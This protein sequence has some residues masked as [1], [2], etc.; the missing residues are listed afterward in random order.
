MNL[1]V[2][3][4]W[5]G[6][7]CPDKSIRGN[8]QVERTDG[9][10]LITAT[11]PKFSVEHHP[12]APSGKRFDGLWDYDVLEIF[13]V[14]EDGKYIEVEL[15]TAGH[16]LVLG[17]DGVRRRANDF[18]DHVFEHTFYREKD[19]STINTIF[20]PNDI[21][22]PLITRVNAFIIANQEFLAHA[23]LP[24]AKAD[25]HQPDAYPMMSV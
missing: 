9:G 2:K 8:F 16:Y 7:E 6:D 23:P 4:R 25:F 3:R 15:G 22:P 13:F 10:L 11:A 21:L 20:I 24:G 5:N 14:G 18:Y 1:E 17:F 12:N 19:G